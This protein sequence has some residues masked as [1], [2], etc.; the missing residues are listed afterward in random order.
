MFLPDDMYVRELTLWYSNRDQK[1]F[2]LLDLR[3]HR[4]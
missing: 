2:V 4:P 1:A 3:R